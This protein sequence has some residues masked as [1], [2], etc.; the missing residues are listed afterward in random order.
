[1]AVATVPAVV[2]ACSSSA[3]KVAHQ[4]ADERGARALGPLHDPIPAVDVQR[5]A[6]AVQLEHA[7]TAFRNSQPD[8]EGEIDPPGR[9]AG[10][11]SM[12]GRFV[13]K[14]NITSASS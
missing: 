6:A 9:D 5:Q 7:S 4:L 13:V 8:F 12:S 11:V 3:R 1:M 2:S 10:R 14:R